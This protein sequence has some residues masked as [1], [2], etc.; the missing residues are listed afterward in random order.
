MSEVFGQRFL[1]LG[2]SGMGMAPLACWMSKAGYSITGYDSNL[3][4]SV[5]KH[6]LASGV[7]LK[8]FVFSEQLGEFDSLVHSSAIREGHPLLD[9]AKSSGIVCMRRGEMLA[10]VAGEHK[11]V[12]IVGSHGKTTTTGMI[13]YGM[14]QCCIEANYILGGLFAD[15]SLS[16]SGYSTSPWMVAE[17]DESDGTIEHFSPEHTLVLNLDWDHADHYREAAHLE[18]TFAGLAQR[19]KSSVF[20]PQ[21]LAL[22]GIDESKVVRYGSGL[23]EGFNARNAAAAIEALGCFMDSDFIENDPLQGF[24]GMARRQG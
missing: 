5:R 8:D 14:Q 6:L 11:L 16:P 19:T 24:P 1:F 15:E 18:A 21:E 9:A 7:V 23:D 22:S 10:R 12:A 17:I 4:E 2:V 13:A 3:Q 20:L